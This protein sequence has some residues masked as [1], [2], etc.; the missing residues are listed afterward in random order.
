VKLLLTT[1]AERLAMALVLSGLGVAS[2]LTWF[3]WAP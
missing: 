2:A 1:R 3:W